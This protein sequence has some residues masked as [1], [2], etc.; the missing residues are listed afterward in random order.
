[1]NTVE[2]RKTIEEMV[3]Y[4][5]RPYPYQSAPEFKLVGSSY[6]SRRTGV[7]VK[8]EDAETTFS[9][10]GEKTMIPTVEIKAIRYGFGCAFAIEKND[11]EIVLIG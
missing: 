7:T 3:P 9:Y 5:A 2:L 1:M 4:G 10:R 8:V 11:G 6:V